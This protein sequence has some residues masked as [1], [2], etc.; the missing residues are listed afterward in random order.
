MTY[1]DGS[2]KTKSNGCLGTSSFLLLLKGKGQGGTAT[3]GMDH[4][5]GGSQ[6]LGRDNVWLT[7]EVWRQ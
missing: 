4:S 5:Y 3:M 1:L 6:V 2:V 7:V